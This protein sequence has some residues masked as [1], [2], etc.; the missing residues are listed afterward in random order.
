MN[1]F[2][3]YIV[4]SIGLFVWYFDHYFFIGLFV[5]CAGA[6]L[7]IKYGDH[8]AKFEILEANI[9]IITQV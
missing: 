2:Q 9:Y 8:H 1:A 3:F 5:L 6:K 7:A 4:F